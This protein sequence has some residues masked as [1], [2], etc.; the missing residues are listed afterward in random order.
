MCLQQGE[1]HSL[2]STCPYSQYLEG[3][4]LSNVALTNDLSG[5]PVSLGLTLLQRA[6]FCPWLS[7]F[8]P[9]TLP[10]IVSPACV[11]LH[12]LPN[13]SMPFYA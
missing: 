10:G 1:T 5:P 8:P 7:T 11:L 3:P 4:N 12:F 2:Q 13:S 6:L 9:Y